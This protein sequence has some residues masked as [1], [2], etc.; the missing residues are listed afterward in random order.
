MISKKV[1][2]IVLEHSETMI[3]EW[4]DSK[5]GPGVEIIDG[6]IDSLSGLTGTDLRMVKHNVRAFILMDMLISAW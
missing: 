6:A 5:D 3:I 1:L 4:A 2:D